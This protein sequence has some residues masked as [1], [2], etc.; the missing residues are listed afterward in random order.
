MFEDDN[1]FYKASGAPIGYYGVHCIMVNPLQMI[2]IF[3][4]LAEQKNQ[5]WVYWE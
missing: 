3:S 5:F 2:Y 4:L 1:T